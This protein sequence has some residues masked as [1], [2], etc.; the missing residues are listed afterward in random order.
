M[1]DICYIG[2]ITQDHIITPTS[3]IYLP[4][5]SYY[6]AKGIQSMD[7][8]K[9]GI[10]FK[11][12]T[13]LSSRDIDI[14]ENL[15]AIGID[16]TVFPSDETLFFENIY[17]TDINQRS[18]RVLAIASPF[19][20]EDLL[21]VKTRFVVLGS[22]LAE[23]FNIDIFKYFYKKSIIAV[24][25]QGFL[26]TVRNQEVHAIDWYWKKDVLKY[27]TILKVNNFEAEV[28]TGETDYYKA[29]EILSSWGVKEI[30]LTLGDKGSIIYH[31]GN[32]HKIPAYKPVKVIDATG[33]GDTYLMGYLLQRAL[34][35]DVNHAGHFGA[36][37]STMK[38]E[39]HGP[40]NG[41]YDKAIERMQQQQ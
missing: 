21:E 39:H 17:G 25:A 18:Q 16:T 22:L 8:S 31:A 34:G 24:D 13:S 37:V 14:V 19:R 20:L 32:F 2:H 29:C 1:N 12:Y 30:L 41:S 10:S 3:D 6:F 38:L 5:G 36:A 23:D 28:L 15:R 35:A 11:L 27:V 7:P 26:R 9:H 4:G 33:C 40:F